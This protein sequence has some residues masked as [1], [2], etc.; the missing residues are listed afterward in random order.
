LFEANQSQFRLAK[1]LKKICSYVSKRNSAA[2]K[3]DLFEANQSHFVLAK[4]VAKIRS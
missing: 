2:L 3:K 4:K 1:R